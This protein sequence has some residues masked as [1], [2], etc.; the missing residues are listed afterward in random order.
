[1]MHQFPRTFSPPKRPSSR[2]L[3][4]D[5]PLTPAAYLHLC[6][7]ASRM[8]V[9]ATAIMMMKDSR[10]VPAAM[11]LVRSLERKGTVAR[12]RETLLALQSAFAFDP[13]VYHQLATEPP[14]R[15]PQICRGCGCSEW[16]QRTELHGA[17][18]WASAHA[19]TRCAGEGASN[20]GRGA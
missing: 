18:A 8:S 11:D 9:S 15:H 5:A 19:C 1:M 4:A 13:D 20:A 12:H 14:E 2:S 6:R 10:E 7:E 16:D 17:F 3:F